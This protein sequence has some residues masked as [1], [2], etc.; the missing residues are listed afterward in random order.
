[1]EQDGITLYS[2]Y[3]SIFYKK[4]GERI[5]NDFF[6]GEIDIIPEE[7][8]NIDIKCSWSLETFPHKLVDPMN[9]DYEYQGRGYMDLNGK[10]RHIIAYCLVNAPGILVVK[11][12][13][14]LWH[15]MNCPA[16]DDPDFMQAKIA[17][18]RNMIFDMEQFRLDNPDVSIDCTDWT[19]D[20]PIK[21]R[22]IE[23]VVDFD[24]EK[25]NAIKNRIRE[26]RKWLLENFSA[27]FT[28][29][30]TYAQVNSP[31]LD[32]KKRV[33][34]KKGERG[35]ILTEPDE[36]NMVVFKPDNKKYPI[37]NAD[38]SSLLFL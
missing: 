12:K 17:I 5:K 4:N 32:A 25:I 34:A 26:C 29:K 13:E 31:L 10:K 24:Q 23:Y 38:L 18:E 20:I 11:E 7:D 1:M 21:D 16:N 33:R 2:R 9:S 14:K 37:N 6:D 3:R 19:Y 27:E 15:N 36:K 8:E 28:L 35:T 30:G 22:V